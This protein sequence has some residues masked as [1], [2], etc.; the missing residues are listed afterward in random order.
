MQR[1]ASKRPGRNQ[2]PPQETSTNP[3]HQNTSD[4]AGSQRLQL[5]TFP[6][7]KRYPIGVRQESRRSYHL[8]DLPV[9]LP[10]RHWSKWSFLSTPLFT[11][12]PKSTP[13]HAD[14]CLLQ[15]DS[16][17]FPTSSTTWYPWKSGFKGVD[18]LLDGKRNAHQN[19]NAT[20][21]KG[22]LIKRNTH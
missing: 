20:H 2:N 19:A 16:S 6:D 9:R 12:F 8:Q 21:Q 1:D 18:F 22:T 5:Y 3:S 13:T 17:A 7:Y 11:R 15:Y 10:V 14:G 4:C